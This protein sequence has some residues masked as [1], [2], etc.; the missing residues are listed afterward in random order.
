MR[1]QRGFTLIELMTAVTVLALLLSAAVPAFDAFTVNTR[2]RAAADQAY[3]DLFAA[4]YEALRSGTRADVE[5]VSGEWEQGWHV[6][7]TD[8]LEDGSDVQKVVSE[9]RA[10]ESRVAITV[11]DAAGNDVSAIRFDPLGAVES[12]DGGAE[13]LISASTRMFSSVRRIRVAA[14]GRVVSE[15]IADAADATCREPAA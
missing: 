11:C 3:R 12:P 4:R 15:K 14:N 2:T 1:R 13:V 8:L 6:T 9:H 7:R 5:A 10:S